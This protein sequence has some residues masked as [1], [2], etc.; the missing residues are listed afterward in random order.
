MSKQHVFTVDHQRAAIYKVLGTRILGSNLFSVF[1]RKPPDE[2]ARRLEQI[3]DWSTLAKSAGYSA[4]ALAFK[5]RISTRQL[6]RFFQSKMSHSPHK[7]L[8]DLRMRR[9]VELVGKFVPMKEVA[10]EL[11]YKD[12]AHFTRDFKEYF[13]VPPSRYPSH[14]ATPPTSSGDHVAI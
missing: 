12:P 7:W 10:A 14:S 1:L 3:K 6:E 13:G 5:C 2:M 4:T 9:A 11:C 8:R